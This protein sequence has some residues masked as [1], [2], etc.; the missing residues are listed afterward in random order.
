MHTLRQ[1]QA[2]KKDHRAWPGTMG[3][4]SEAVSVVM[5]GRH[6]ESVLRG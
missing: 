4:V 2:V 6:E 5:E 3:C 1:Q